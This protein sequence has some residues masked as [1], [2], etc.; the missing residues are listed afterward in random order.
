MLTETSI[1]M[2]AANNLVE[3]QTATKFEILDYAMPLITIISIF[4]TVFIA[5]YNI[6]NTKEITEMSLKATTKN[7]IIQ[8][9]QDEIKESIKNLA[10]EVDSG[11]VERIRKFMYSDKGIYIPPSLKGKIEEHLNGDLDVPEIKVVLDLINTWKG[12]PDL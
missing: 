8:L 4:A 11:E 9:N 3:S 7:L 2:E 6:K 1:L 12:Y 10:E 5:Y